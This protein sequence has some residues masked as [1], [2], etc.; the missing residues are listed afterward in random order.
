MKDVR[1]QFDSGLMRAEIW[2]DPAPANPRKMNDNLSSMLF[3]HQRYQLGDEQT[4][5][6]D[7]LMDYVGQD[8]V[9][10]AP[11]WLYGHSGLALRMGGLSIGGG[12]DNQPVRF[13]SRDWDTSFLGFMTL[14][15]KKAEEEYGPDWR[16]KIE[17]IERVFRSELAEYMAYLNGNVYGYTIY[18]GK[19][20]ETCE[21]IQWE[22]V[23][24]CG[25]FID[26]EDMPDSV[27]HDH[28]ALMQG[29][30]DLM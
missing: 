22:E 4:V 14:D 6:T 19:K 25:G 2:Y 15:F 13:A 1:A 23:D 7:Q 3:Y 28:A 30:V 8:D 11:V 20:C 10:S 17:T 5:N 24:S 26:P 29:A 16:S 12:P 27:H 18:E 21:I 9:I